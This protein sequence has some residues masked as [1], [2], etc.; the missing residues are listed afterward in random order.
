VTLTIGDNIDALAEDLTDRLADKI[1][2]RITGLL[3][4]RLREPDPAEL[5]T[6]PEAADYIRAKSRRIY[7]LTREG[8]L[9]VERDGRR[10]LIRRGTLDR[11]LGG[12]R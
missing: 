2:E 1:A 4:E 3:A 12:N 5:M 7:E 6:V 11:Y 8:R 9:D 10:I